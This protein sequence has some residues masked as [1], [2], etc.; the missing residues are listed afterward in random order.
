MSKYVHNFSRFWHYC[1]SFFSIAGNALFLALTRNFF[2]FSLSE[3][4]FKGRRNLPLPPPI[5]SNPKLK[6][7]QHSSKRVQ[8]RR[9]SGR[10]NPIFQ[11]SS[12]ERI[13]VRSL[14]LRHHD[15]KT[16]PSARPRH[17]DL[18]HRRPS[19]APVG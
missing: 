1:L 10:S 16:S 9:K 5:K 11:K 13:G 18:R 2:F 15:V 6:S 7:G 4:F 12:R 3:N 8:K 17:L 19:H 14:D